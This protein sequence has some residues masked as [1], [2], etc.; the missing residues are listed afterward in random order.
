[1]NIQGTIT[2]RWG[3]I[4][5][6]K[7]FSLDIYFCPHFMHVEVMR[8]PSKNIFLHPEHRVV[9]VVHCLGE[10]VET[11]GLNMRISL[12]TR[13]MQEDNVI[14]LCRGEVCVDTKLGK[15]VTTGCIPASRGSP[16]C[17]ADTNK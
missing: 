4:C 17:L 2:H 1:M 10:G 6:C 12:A 15:Y 8:H 16:C 11:R 3:N 9:H 5:S 7:I 13:G 14:F